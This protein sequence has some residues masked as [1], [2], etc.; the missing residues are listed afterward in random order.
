MAYLREEKQTVEID[1]ALSEVWA[2]IPEVLASLEW[3]VE[4]MDDSVH[5]S[6]VKT[7]AAFMSYRSTLTIDGTPVDEKKCRITV[8]GE[9]PITT[10][11]A[12]ADFGRT[13]DRIQLFFETLAKR[14][15]T[16]KKS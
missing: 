8:K 14:L 5:H 10:L 9:T 3:P 13:S 7:K 16:A 4:E 6:K 1:Y 15:Y 11:T 2:A 12:M